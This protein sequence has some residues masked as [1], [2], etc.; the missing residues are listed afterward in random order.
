MTTPG[1]GNRERA[2][3]HRRAWTGFGATLLVCSVFCYPVVLDEGAGRIAAMERAHPGV[4]FC[5]VR[6]PRQEMALWICFV[7]AL[8]A[9][10]IIVRGLLIRPPAA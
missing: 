9:L 4:A 1:H 2:A 10:G 7:N 5:F 8:A 3:D 6:D